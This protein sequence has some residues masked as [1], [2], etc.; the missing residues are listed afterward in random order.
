M[1]ILSLAHTVYK[2]IR[3]YSTKQEGGYNLTQYSCVLRS[4][5]DR[6]CSMEN[7]LQFYHLSFFSTPVLLAEQVYYFYWTP[8]AGLF[9]RGSL[10]FTDFLAVIVFSHVITITYSI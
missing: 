7:T 8:V 2:K 6:E 1:I 9:K 5:E 10:P 3:I 4:F